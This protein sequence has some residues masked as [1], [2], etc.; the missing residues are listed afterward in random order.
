L[1]V[2]AM[3]DLIPWEPF[4]HLFPFDEGIYRSFTGFWQPSI[5]VSERSDSF[6]VR[7]NL[8]GL[9]REDVQLTV[10]ENSLTIKGDLKEDSTDQGE[11][12]YRRERRFGSF[13]RRIPF[14]G[15]IK[16]D[17]VRAVFKDGVLEVLL[18]KTDRQSTNGRRVEI[19]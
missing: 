10:D 2:K 5:D 16:E 14:H 6:I 12:Y 9:N 19:Q 17:Q 18:P 8:P 11:H 15:R 4:S 13:M 7:A 1:E 3:S